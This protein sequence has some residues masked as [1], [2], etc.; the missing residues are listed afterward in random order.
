MLSAFYLY[1]LQMAFSVSY[2]SSFGIFY[3]FICPDLSLRASFTP[4]EQAYTFSLPFR[5]SIS[6]L[7]QR[8]SRDATWVMVGLKHVF[9]SSLEIW[10]N[11]ECVLER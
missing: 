8:R 6:G 5:F 9:L 10:V 7:T 2:F 3:Q 1:T 4:F 11:C